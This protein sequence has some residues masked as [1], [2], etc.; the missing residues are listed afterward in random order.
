VECLEFEYPAS[1]LVTARAHVG[2]VGSGDLEI[3][4]EPSADDRAHVS[5]RTGVAGYARIWKAVL[6]RFFSS[7]S[8]AALIVINDGGA[9]PPVV[10]LRLRQAA[11]QSAQVERHRIR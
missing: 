9:T 5:I 3:L 8:G 2:S 4:L 11:E 6:D 10:L 7:Y 1:T